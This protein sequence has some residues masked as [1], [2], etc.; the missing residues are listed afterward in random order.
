MEFR[1]KPWDWKQYK[2]IDWW[3]NFVHSF[4]SLFLV[5]LFSLSFSHFIAFLISFSLGVLWEVIVDGLFHQ[6][7]AGFDW[8]DI[9][10]DFIGSLI[11][12]ILC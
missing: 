5:K 8:H 4:G 2:E 3:W 7:P 10:A 6:D 1:V 12:G 9:I 11:G